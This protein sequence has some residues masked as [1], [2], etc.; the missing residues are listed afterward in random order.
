MD[1]TLS[2]R[3]DYTV[4]AAISLAGAWSP[5]GN[6]R[7]MREIAADMGLP[8]TYA[9]Q[10][11]GRL[12]RADLVSARAGPGGGYRLTRDPS[13][14]TLLEVVEAGEGSL[15]PRR[16]TLRGGPCRWADVCA[17]HPSWSRATSAVRDALAA[18][19]LAEVADTDRAIN[20]GLFPV[21]EDGHRRPQSRGGNRG[22]DGVGRGR[23]D[24]RD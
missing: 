12:V 4:R 20:S 7:K 10:I 8:P 19:T 17:V 15:G 23:P 9:P 5:E 6:S 11:F 16:C 14:I 21:S 2:R 13:E 1:L 22:G 24:Q 3:G 18:T